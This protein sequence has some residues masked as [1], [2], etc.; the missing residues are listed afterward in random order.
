VSILEAMALALPVVS[1]TIG[2]IPELVA[3]GETGLLVE[4]GDAAQLR[5]A[6]ARLLA[7]PDL[8]VRLGRAGASRAAE[9]FDADDVAR[10]MVEIYR[11][12]RAA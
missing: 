1:T 7:D 12:L 3:D 11:G 8:C 9:R 10:R 5:D 4:P 6:L 2:G